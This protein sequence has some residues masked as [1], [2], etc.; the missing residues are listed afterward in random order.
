MNT[1]ELLNSVLDETLLTSPRDLAVALLERIPEDSYPD[2]LAEILPPWVQH[3]LSRRRLL[4][5][6][7]LIQHN[8][9]SSKVAAVRD[10]A[11]RLKTPLKVGDEWK[12]L[13]DCTR[14]DLLTVA[15]SLRE[16][17][18]RSIAKAEYYE[19]LAASVPQGGTVGLLTS[20]PVGVLT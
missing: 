9:A 10:W 14:D 19:D 5:V 7:P 13:A 3:E 4:N 11:A 15:S 2:F 17:A 8:T 18:L 6:R 20:D 12:R 16:S 1:H